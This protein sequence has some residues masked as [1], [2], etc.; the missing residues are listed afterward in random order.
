MKNR[1][2]L[3][4]NCKYVKPVLYVSTGTLFYMKK[5]LIV[6]TGRIDAMH[7][8]NLTVEKA[9][10][11]FCRQYDLL[12]TEETADFLV[13]LASSYRLDQLDTTRAA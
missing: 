4:E 3:T 9:A 8:S 7:V 10:G 6:Y 1:S 13:T 2:S 12:T 11:L 5:S